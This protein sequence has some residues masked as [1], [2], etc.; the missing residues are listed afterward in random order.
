MAV[1]YGK[2]NAS[3]VEKINPMRRL[4]LEEKFVAGGKYFR[5]LDSAQ[6]SKNAIRQRASIPIHAG[7]RED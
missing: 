2:L 1:R 6:G 7:M 3:T 5:C 4:A